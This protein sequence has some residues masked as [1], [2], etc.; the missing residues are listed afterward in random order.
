MT[1]PASVIPARGLI[2]APRLPEKPK[3]HTGN[4]FT[5]DGDITA[6]CAVEGCGWH[7]M[8][9]RSVM[10]QVIDRHHKLFH[11]ESIGVVLLNQARQ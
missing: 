8:G 1:E 4:P 5:S 2:V 7:A 3:D 11:S 6:D 10:K 9:P